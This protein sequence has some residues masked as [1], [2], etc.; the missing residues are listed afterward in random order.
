MPNMRETISFPVSRPEAHEHVTWNNVRSGVGEEG[1]MS[2]SSI[3]VVA[4]AA[5]ELTALQLK[6]IEDNR[7][8]AMRI[9]AAKRWKELM[10][11]FS[12][13]SVTV[14]SRDAQF[15]KNDWDAM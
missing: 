13:P 7:L 4:P 6:M 9:R 14:V 5:P 3:P 1:C 2:E 8:N 12:L 11:A 15:W 10:S